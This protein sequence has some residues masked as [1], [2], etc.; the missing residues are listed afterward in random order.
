LAD[1]S[2]LED[3]FPSVDEDAVTFSGLAGVPNKSLNASVLGSY[4]LMKSF[5]ACF[6]AYCMNLNSLC[7][8]LMICAS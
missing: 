2:R 6:I 5:Y 1:D 8:P 7:I 4:K 3:F